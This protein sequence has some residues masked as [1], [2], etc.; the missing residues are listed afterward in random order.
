MSAVFQPERGST[1][2]SS[3]PLLAGADLERPLTG[4]QAGEGEP[5]AVVGAAVGADQV[6]RQADTRGGVETF[7]EEKRPGTGATIYWSVYNE[8]GSAPEGTDIWAVQNGFVSVTPL[9]IDATESRA[10]DTVRGWF[11]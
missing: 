2:A 8:G 5:Q 10:L 3:L 6:T 4:R 9:T 1:S 11:R 7:A